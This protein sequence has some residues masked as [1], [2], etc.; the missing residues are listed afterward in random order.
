MNSAFEINYIIVFPYSNIFRFHV[1]AADGTGVPP[2][3][4]PETCRHCKGSGMVRSPLL[5]LSAHFIYISVIYVSSYQPELSLCLLVWK[6]MLSHLSNVVHR[7]ICKQ[8]PSG[9]K[10]HVPSVA[11]LAKLLK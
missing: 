1:I 5:H 6:V 10:Q 11:V 9:C 2:G 8:D 3:T 4:K 7:Y